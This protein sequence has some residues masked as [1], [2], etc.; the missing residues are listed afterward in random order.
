MTE[1]RIPTKQ[2]MRRA[3]TRKAISDAAQMLFSKRP[4]DAVAID[5]I[6]AAASVAK[7]S[8][9]NYFPSKDALVTDIVD[10]IRESLE[11]R[12]AEINAGEP[13]AARRVAR[14]VCVYMRYAIDQPERAALLVRVQQG[15]L[16]TS[17]PYNHAVVDDVEI[18]MA[19][20]RFSVPTVESGTIFILAIAQ[21][22]IVRIVQEPE[23]SYA[24]QLAQELSS[25]LI[26]GLGVGD[27]EASAIA[28]DAADA[29]VNLKGEND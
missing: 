14:A 20:R 8:F 19:Q 15:Y 5:E 12:V 17:I 16:A 28:S 1:R 9:Y 4:V 23:P 27:A 11:S 22:G 2:A 24:V 13:D 29:I 10:N 6:V 7:G 3:D 26:R 18:G 25:L 21:I